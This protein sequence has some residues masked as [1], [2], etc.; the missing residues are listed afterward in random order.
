VIGEA[1]ANISTVGNC[2]L[3]RETMVGSETP[4]PPRRAGSSPKAGGPAGAQPAVRRGGPSSTALIARNL[5]A[6][7]SMA[8][9]GFP[10][11]LHDITQYPEGWC[12]VATDLA[13]S[14]APR[15]HHA[16]P[17]NTPDR[18]TRLGRNTQNKGRRHV[19][20]CCDG[21]ACFPRWRSLNRLPQRQIRTTGANG[22][23]I[24]AQRSKARGNHE[25][26]GL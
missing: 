9:G 1:R 22:V 10:R 19:S 12:S 21:V 24:E 7:Y 15:D 8:M 23:A 16:V 14:R 6:R 20:F 11:R 18:N 17:D 2:A 4:S 25:T 26:T 3:R 13:H 5:P